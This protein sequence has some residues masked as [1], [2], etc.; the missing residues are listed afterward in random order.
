MPVGIGL[1]PI[2]GELEENLIIAFNFSGSQH[3]AWNDLPCFSTGGCKKWHQSKTARPTVSPVH[4][5]GG[6]FKNSRDQK[7][8]QSSWVWK[9]KHSFCLSSG[10]EAQGCFFKY[11]CASSKVR[12]VGFFVVFFFKLYSFFF[13]CLFIFFN[14]ILDTSLVKSTMKC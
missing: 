12:R 9:G 10:T 13:P 5:K 2:L 14:G 3:Q 4:H 7:T 11:W 6:R 8:K 1:F